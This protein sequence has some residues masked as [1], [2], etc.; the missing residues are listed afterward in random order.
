MIDVPRDDLV[1][2]LETGYIY[3]AMGKF[4][5]A[6]EVFE[7]IAALAP[8]HE[9][10][11]VAQGLVL[12]AQKKFLPAIRLHKEAVALN[13]KSAFAHAHLGEAYLFSG[14]REE[15]RKSLDK[16]SELEP[17]GKAGEFA[18]GLK[19]LMEKGYDPTQ[20]KITSPKKKAS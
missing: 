8:K 20:L 19:Q 14:K 10:P 5:Q 18:R 13:P 7:G 9:V 17:N 4:V 11:V 12:F 16:A 15:A 3:L 2:M 6:R 1:L